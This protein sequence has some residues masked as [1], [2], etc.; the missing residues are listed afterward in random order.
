[1]NNNIQLDPY[2]FF[3]GNCREAMEFYQS[4][5]GGELVLQT[6]GEALGEGA[7][8]DWREKIMH[9]FLSGG[10]ARLMACDS[11]QANEEARKIELSLSGSNEARL[12]EIFE[13]LSEGG[14]VK[15][16]LEKQF[17]GDTFGR[18]WDRYGIDWMVNISQES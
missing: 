15:Q 16:P 6:H 8:E 9:A 14:K 12:R 7:P 11:K 3:T 5:F 1:M 4:V 10:D 18:L 13:K 2:I 17:W